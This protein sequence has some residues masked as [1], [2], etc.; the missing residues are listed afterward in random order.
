[1]FR[2]RSVLLFCASLLALAA[3]LSLSAGQAAPPSPARLA[4]DQPTPA[5]LD[6]L[7]LAPAATPPLI[8]GTVFYDQDGDGSAESPL[9][10]RGQRDLT[11]TLYQDTGVVGVYEPGVD[12]F[13]ATAA[14]DIIGKYLFEALAPDNYLVLLDLADPDLPAGFVATTANPI[15]AA[16]AAGQ[17]QTADPGVRARATAAVREVVLSEI[18][19]AGTSATALT[20]AAFDPE[21]TSDEWLELRNTTGRTIDLTGWTLK[22]ADG[23]PNISLRGRIPPYGYY[24]LER[25]DDGSAP[26][27]TADQI[28]TGALGN[29]GEDLTLSD[30]VTTIDRV[31]AWYA[32]SNT[33]F[34]TMVRVD[35]TR[36]GTD[37]AAWADGPVD[38]DPRNSLLDADGDTYSYSPNPVQTSLSLDC[39][40]TNVT[41]HPGAPETL[42]QVD[43]DCDY[44][45]DEGL[46]L[47]PYARAL[48]FTDAIDALGP[49]ETVGAA[50]AALQALLD[51][52]TTSIDAAIYDFS[53]ANL[54]DALLNAHGRGVQVRV[55]GDDETYQSSMYQPFYQ[56]LE[57]AGIPVLYDMRGTSSLEHNKFALIDGT[58]VWTGSLNW[59][60][61]AA[62]YNAEN[63]L[64][65][66]S[67]H[68][69]QAYTTEFQEMFDP[70]LGCNGVCK[71]DNTTHSF[72]LG[73]TAVRSY[74]SPTDNVEAAILAEVN[75]ATESVYFAMFYLTSDPIG[76]ALLSRAAA[77]VTVRG[78]FDA[79]G[80]TNA[81]SQDEKLCTA[82]LPIKVETFG[83]K[84]H[85]KFAVLDINGPNP[86][87]ITG[88]YNWTAAGA[89]TNDENTLIIHDAATAQA[90][91]GEFLRL[92]QAIPPDALCSRHSAE[93]GIPACQD[94]VDN[95]SDNLI[96]A[97]D[98]RG[99]AST[100]A[101][102][103]DGLDNDG[104]G[105]TD[106][107]DLDCYRCRLAA[108]GISGG[109]TVEAGDP[110]ALTLDLD[111][112]QGPLTYAWSDHSATTPTA[113]YIWNEPGIYLVM[114]SATNWCRTVSAQVEVTVTPMAV[115]WL[116]ISWGAGDA[117]QLD[118][119]Y[120]TPAGIDHYEVWH[121]LNAP[122]FTPGSCSACD[123]PWTTGDLFYLDT[124]SHGIGDVAH[125]YFY[126]VR[127]AKATGALSAGSNTAGEFDF[128]LT[129]GQ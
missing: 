78:I 51:G 91:H 77:G 46:T 44:Q 23:T 123:P 65:I 36:P 128:A 124:L 67:P 127:A 122:Y 118:W 121:S 69:A 70:L 25:T 56:A 60:N 100:P 40:D 37:P 35:V 90:Y 52:A 39:N 107:V 87:V 17:S 79:V 43:Q 102:C 97:A 21:T 81:Y 12:I 49:T 73:G 10:D 85:H 28:Y 50:D 94:G 64:A 8:R 19:W 6:V 109:A 7:A 34:K 88:S 15:A 103:L 32:G 129:P 120:V 80:A 45:V 54:R 93:S 75:A 57:A 108:T 111:P 38:G 63:G 104:D 126:R 58:T 82:G 53:R 106:T 11:V 68:L 24:L 119:T 31:D 20:A 125:N 99:R 18:A 61:T 101:L 76:D 66:V 30:G 55:M 22:A 112:A 14:S 62:T 115:P 98:P 114:A 16:L 42:D 116:S 84:V 96:D 9:C 5:E 26:A 89:E 2:L 3:P 29:T 86:R 71:H 74:F 59:S 47:E 13:V 4:M 117:A 72:D 41:I 95:H 105:K 27:A 113:T 48:Y 1:M 92:Y 33:T 110:L 83:G